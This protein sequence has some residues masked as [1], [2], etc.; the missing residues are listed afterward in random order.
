MFVIKK[1]RLNKFVERPI[2]SNRSLFLAM[3][4]K[5]ASIQSKDTSECYSEPT[6]EGASK[7][8]ILGMAAEITKVAYEKHKTAGESNDMNIKNAK[9]F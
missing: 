4:E 5:P 3:G 1:L 6:P 9:E 7:T 2:V 8:K